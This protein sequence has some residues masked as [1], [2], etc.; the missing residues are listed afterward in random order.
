MS[1]TLVAIA[2]A[3]YNL[4]VTVPIYIAGRFAG[5]LSLLCAALPFIV[6]SL[7]LGVAVGVGVG[8]YGD[9]VLEESEYFL[10]CVA[11]P[12]WR[13]FVRPIFTLL[14]F[15]YNILIC[16]WNAINWWAFGIWQEAIIPT[17]TDCGVTIPAQRVGDFF[18]ALFEDLLVDWIISGDFLTQ[19][20]DFTNINA[21][22]TAFW[23]AWQ[24]L[25]ACSCSDL[26]DFFRLQPLLIYNPLSLLS[27]LPESDGLPVVGDDIPGDEELAAVIEIDFPASTLYFNPFF[28]LGADQAKDPQFLCAVSNAFN[29]LATIFHVLWRLLIQVLTLQ[30]I[31]PRPNFDRT[32]ELL[33]DAVACF[34]RSVEN[35]FQGFTDAFVPFDFVWENVLCI[36]DV[37]FCIV[38]DAV[39]FV[40]ALIINI[41][42]VVFY[43]SNPFWGTDLKTRVR[44][45]LNRVAF[46]TYKDYGIDPNLDPSWNETRLSECICLLITRVIC[47]QT[48]T[49][50]PC[51]GSG[52]QE[53]LGSI[54]FDIC[55]LTTILLRS[56]VNLLAFIFELTLNFSSLDMFFTF[57]DQD[58][59]TWFI[60]VD[61]VE[62]ADCLLD[63][64][65][66]IPVVG[67]C[68]KRILVD[69][70]LFA[71]CLADIAVKLILG[72]A[73]LPYW[74][75]EGRNNY[76]L[77]PQRARDEFLMAIDVVAANGTNT[78]MNCLCFVLNGAFPIPYIPCTSCSPVG[79]LPP[80]VS[81]RFEDF[82][83]DR[84]MP[85]KRVYHYDDENKL[86][87]KQLVDNIY[88]NSHDFRDKVRRIDDWQLQQIMTPGGN[89]GEFIATQL[90][91][92]KQQ[93]EPPQCPQPYQPAF[94]QCT[95]PDCF[96]VCCA[97]RTSIQ[98]IA[99]ILRMVA[100]GVDSLIHETQGPAE[101]NYFVNGSFEQDLILSIELGLLPLQCICNTLEFVFPIPNLDLCCAVRELGNLI[102]G[103]LLV[104]IN[105]IKSLALDNPNFTYFTDTMS[106]PNFRQDINDLSDISLVVVQCICDVFRAVLPVP[107]LDICCFADR[108][109]SAIVEIIRWL[110]NTVVNLALINDGGS[111]YFDTGGGFATEGEVVI[112]SFFGTRGGCCN[113]GT[114][115]VVNCLCGVINAVFPFRQFPGEPVSGNNCPSLDLCCAINEV[116]F[117][118]G[119]VLRFLLNLLVSFFQPWV[120]GI[121]TGVVEFW[122]CNDLP[123]TLQTSCIYN[124]TTNAFECFQSTCTFDTITSTTLCTAVE[125][126]PNCGRLQPVFESLRRLLECP[127][128]VLGFLDQ[129]LSEALGSQWECFCG[130]GQTRP[131]IVVAIASFLTIILEKSVE[132]FRLFVTDVYWAPA[133]WP[134]PGG[135]NTC[136]EGSFALFLI[137][138]IVDE[139]C[140]LI[141]SITCFLDAWFGVNACFATQR[142]IVF[143]IVRWPFE[144]V[145]RIIDVF[146]GIVD[147]F[148]N[149]CDSGA[150][151]GDL[152]TGMPPG[153]YEQGAQGGCIGGGLTN[154]FA[155]FIDGL[156]GDGQLPIQVPGVTE[157]PTCGSVVVSVSQPITFPVDCSCYEGTAQS[158]F[159]CPNT[160]FDPMVARFCYRFL[161]GSNDTCDY[162]PGG[163]GDRIFG[164]RPPPQTV[165]LGIKVDGILIALLRYI[166]CLLNANGA[167]G[168]AKATEGLTVFF[169]FLWQ[170]AGRI[171]NFI[172]GVIDFFVSLL[173]FDSTDPCS[174]HASL[175]CNFGLLCYEN[176]GK[177]KGCNLLGPSEATCSLLTV[178]ERAFQTL[179]LF[180]DIFNTVPLVPPTQVPLTR[181]EPAHNML[182]D[183]V[184]TLWDFDTS[185]CITDPVACVQRNMPGAL[186]HLDNETEITT[187]EMIQ[188]L[189]S[190]FNPH[191]DM[192]MQTTCQDIVHMCAVKNDTWDTVNYSIKTQY[193]EC[194]VARMRAERV[195]MYVPGV[196]ADIFYNHRGPAEIIHLLRSHITD[197]DQ[198]E[199][200]QQEHRREYH[201]RED[202]FIPGE[203]HPQRCRR[204]MERRSFAH[205][206]MDDQGWKNPELKSIFIALDQR[207]QLI[208]SGEL[209]H[210]MNR[211][212]TRIARGEWRL[213]LWT[214]TK[215]LAK[216]GGHV[217]RFLAKTNY[218]GGMLQFLDAVGGVWTDTRR[219]MDV[220]IMRSTYNLYHNQERKVHR[221]RKATDKRIDAMWQA[222]YSGPLYQWYNSTKQRSMGDIYGYGNITVTEHLR[223]TMEHHRERR[224]ALPYNWYDGF[225]AVKDDIVGKWT[226]R[227]TR[228]KLNNWM[229]VTGVTL[230]MYNKIF[231]NDPRIH[232][233]IQERFIFNSNCLLADRATQ[234]TV[235]LVQYCANEFVANIPSARQNDAFVEFAKRSKWHAH[236]NVQYYEHP[237]Q[238]RWRRDDYEASWETEH[239]QLDR[240][241]RIWN[242]PHIVYP[243]QHRRQ[244]R[245]IRAVL[246][247][248]PTFNLIDWILCRI[249][250]LLMASGNS[251]LSQTIAQFIADVQ[252][253]VLNMN[254][255]ILAGPVGLLYWVQFPFIC[256]FP[257][258]LNCSVGI[259][260][261]QAI[262]FAFL[263]TLILF[264]GVALI[265]PSILTPLA[266]LSFLLYVVLVPAMAWHYSPRCWLMTPAATWLPTTIP[267]SG[268]LPDQDGE[269]ITIPILGQLSEGIDFPFW[270]FPIAF[271]A[272]PECL[273]D[274][275]IAL[276]DKWITDCYA[277]LEDTSLSW[278]LPPQMV[279]G[280]LCP[281]CPTKID[282][283]NCR[284]VGVSD[285]LANIVYLLYLIFPGFCDFI[286]V[287]LQGTCLFNGMCL[288]DLS[289]IS[290]LLDTFKMA[291]DTQTYRFNWCSV[292]TGGTLGI[293][294]AVAILAF[295]LLSFILPSLIQIINGL[296]L[297]IVAP[298]FGF[299]SLALDDEATILPDDGN[300]YYEGD[301]EELQEVNAAQ[302]GW[303]NK[304]N[305][306]IDR[307]VRQIKQD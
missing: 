191:A 288:L 305:R 19:E 194:L 108:L 207:E 189:D 195:R 179:Q 158:A 216:R 224:S 138:R 264:V 123:N 171:L 219:L 36:V 68:I 29:S 38:A 66:L 205:R 206:I 180:F 9:V 299:L 262:G 294:V 282:V 235:D 100:F 277:F 143:A 150:T 203:T 153:A 70:V 27:N 65:G 215:R 273:L 109:W 257:L 101:Q 202:S 278:L 174:C 24:A 287:T 121:P 293:A 184:D 197:L 63:L 84:F 218:A 25:L 274:E 307:Y 94:G 193:S 30:P 52:A 256:Q 80:P 209:M 118:I 11:F 127:C 260:L 199:A 154:L 250:D 21:T 97:L 64:L 210:Q 10:R 233:G 286:M 292:A 31:D 58:F 306:Y 120:N 115:G 213:P 15:I 106:T 51:F 245:S 95:R 148:V 212:R 137:G 217:V 196:P 192:P 291:T 104:I 71:A 57:L 285:G 157:L 72:L 42:Q 88:K 53:I 281:V 23:E 268:L 231:P 75:I 239:E 242:R 142:N 226:P 133:N 60:K 81:K 128:V 147:A 139:L 204:Y 176:A 87:P 167:S 272:L 267:F 236:P 69:F 280:P 98:A 201:A 32:L 163:L 17:L 241:E 249:D 93:V 246:S 67:F 214:A 6:I 168:I 301:F 37:A 59:L 279:N 86:S 82:F 103:I 105:G 190:Y 78:W 91:H 166:T 116:G 112:T 41:D 169:S 237:N 244:P 79:F 132:F 270:P 248:T 208:R 144:I 230:R 232:Q 16:W 39:G 198:Q 186:Q 90:K 49:G 107:V 50:A 266:I 269:P 177:G 45:G 74:I 247:P 33:C 129:L 99:Q 3:A 275:L 48:N 43:P 131:G 96:D 141:F 220:G 126:S 34:I 28:L 304:L 172:G 255:D 20:L 238:T 26:A 122:V 252:A 62:I 251:A 284:D 223:R 263:W 56:I 229:K 22:W 185:D 54:E 44:R 149:G 188:A 89:Y 2:A 102:A 254:T 187:G 243:Q 298:L 119:D 211:A 221:V 130:T 181:N 300:E 152:G 5:F 117:F 296:W 46:V 160:V 7:V 35:V 73:T 297:L 146:Q 234:L 136:S 183:V 18:I 261:E 182:E 124:T 110:V 77:E 175:P 156:I 258:N 92:K 303:G 164:C 162:G 14:R 200:E 159:T 13:D 140:E 178:F 161:P 12:L 240:R 47:D 227:W 225:Q 170:L 145:I 134:C 55:C 228:K 302:P 40:L 253:F 276:G 289:Y 165:V 114:G 76:I 259:G 151:L 1:A 265:F 295:A 83:G 111:A 173:S 85:S 283:A 8:A 155:F 61:V 290:D 113:Q 271:P 125:L 4:F 222:F 135:A